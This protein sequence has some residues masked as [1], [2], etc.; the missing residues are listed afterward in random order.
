MIFRNKHNNTVGKGFQPFRLIRRHKKTVSL[1]LALLFLAGFM[2]PQKLFGLTGGPSSPEVSSPSKIT[3]SK[4]VDP[5][6][7]DL[8]YSISLL[9]VGDYPL[10]LSYNPDISMDQEASWVGLGWTLNPGSISRSVRGLPDDFKGKDKVEKDFN[11]KANVKAGLNAGVNLELFGIDAIGVTG[12]LGASVGLFY[13]N[14]QGAGLNYSLSPSITVGSASKGALTASMGINGGSH[15]NGISMQ[16]SLSFPQRMMGMESLTIS[17]KFNSLSGLKSVNLNVGTKNGI[18]DYSATFNSFTDRSYKPQIK[19]PMISTHGAFSFAGGGEVFGTF[20]SG[21]ITGYYSQQHLKKKHKEVPAFGYMYTEAAENRSDA[22]LD[23]KREKDGTFTSRK[24]NLPLPNYTYDVFNISGAGMSGSFRAHR[25]DVGVLY[26][27]YVKSLGGDKAVKAVGGF[28]LSGEVGGGNLVKVGIDLKTNNSVN[29]SGKWDNNN[30]IF[31]RIDPVNHKEASSKGYEPFYFK[32]SG[33]KQVRN[34]PSFYNRVLNRNPASV[35]LASQPKAKAYQTL[36]GNKDSRELKNSVYKDKRERRMS[37]VSYLTADI[38]DRMALNRQIKNYPLNKTPLNPGKASSID[39]LSGHR[40]KH[41]LSQIMLQNEGKRYVYGIPTYNNMKKEASFNVRDKKAN[42]QNGFVS[43]NAGKSNST[44]NKAGQNHYYSATTTPAYAYS[45]LLTSVVSEDY[46]DISG[47]GPTPDDMGTYTRFNYSRVHKNYKWRSPYRKNKANYQENKY[48]LDKENMA[49]YVYGKKEVWYINSIETRNYV[50]RF[51]IS[52]RK[53]G[54]GVKG[55]N[56]GKDK[57][58]KLKKLDKIQLFTRADL[59]KHGK[60]A[61]PLKTVHFEYDY[62]LCPGIPNQQNTNKGKLTLQ[63]IY[64]T[65]GNSSKGRFSPYDFT[66]HKGNKNPSYKLKSNDRFGFYKENNCQSGQMSNSEF[67]YVV[68]DTSKT[69]RFIKAW[70]LKKIQVPSGGTINIHYESD[71]YSYVQDKRAMQMFK[72][73]GFSDKRNPDRSKFTRKLYETQPSYSVNNYLF[74]DLKEPVTSREELKAYLPDEDHLY[75]KTKVDVIGSGGN[76]PSDHYEYISGFAKYQ[77]FGLHQKSKNGSSYSTAWI[78]L[79]KPRIGDYKLKRKY[80][81]KKAHPIAKRAWI[82]SKN[83]IPKH[84]FDRSD[85]TD[86]FGNQLK[87]AL[88]SLGEMMTML[89]SLN[90]KLIDRKFAKK[91]KLN[92]SIVRLNVP[93]GR[94][95]GGGHR[96]KKIVMSD[97]WSKMASKGNTSTYGNVYD[98]TTTRNGEKISS[99]VISY[100][101]RIGQEENPFYQPIFYKHN[102]DKL[103]MTKPFGSSFFPGPNVGYS[104]IEIHDLPRPGANPAPSGYKVREFYTAKDFP[105]ITERTNLQDEHKRRNPFAN[106]NPFKFKFNERRAVSQ[107]YKVVLNDMHGKPKAKYTYRHGAKMPLNGVEYKYKTGKHGRLKNNVK[108]V[109]KDKSIKEATLGVDIDF[110]VDARQQKSVTEMKGININTDGFLASIIPVVVPV[111]LPAYKKETVLFR[112]IVTTKVIRKKGIIDEVITY[113]NGSKLKTENL[114]FDAVTGKV[115]VSKNQNKYGNY[116]YKTNIPAHHKYDGMG[117]AYRN[118][119]ASFEKVQVKNGKITNRQVNNYLAKGDKLYWVYPDDKTTYNKAWVLKSNKNRSVLIDM[120]GDLLPNAKYNLTVV[121]SGYDDQSRQKVGKVSSMKNPISGNKLDLNRNIKVLKASA[122]RYK[123][124]WQTYAGFKVEHV[125][126]KCKCQL[127]NMGKGAML[128]ELLK[129]I[130]NEAEGA[131]INNPRLAKA[132]KQRVGDTASFLTL[133][134]DRKGNLLIGGFKLNGRGESHC[135]VE[136]EKP[137]GFTLPDGGTFKNYRYVKKNPYRCGDIYN[138]KVDF[139]YSYKDTVY[140]DYQTHKEQNIVRKTDTVTLKVHSECFP[141]AHCHE[142][143]LKSYFTCNLKPGDIVNPFVIGILGNW[144]SYKQ[145]TYHTS[146][147]SDRSQNSGYYKS[148]TP[149][150]W[151]GKPANDWVWKKETNLIDPFERSLEEEDPLGNH[152]ANIYGYSYSHVKASIQNGKHNRSGYDGFE[153]YEYYGLVNTFGNCT[154]QKHMHFYL[155]QGTNVSGVPIP[156]S[157]QLKYISD[158]D[159]HTGEYSARI[160]SAAP[161]VMKRKV[162]PYKGGGNQGSSPEYKLHPDDYVGI[163][164]PKPGKYYISA[165]VKDKL[166][167]VNYNTLTYQ[168]PKVVVTADG[169][170]VTTINPSGPVVDG[171]QQMNGSFVIPKNTNVVKVKL[172]T[173]FGVAFFD[174]FRIHP[175]NAQMKSYVYN[176]YNLRHTATLDNNNYAIFFQ[177]NEEGEFVGTKKETSN[178]IITVKNTRHGSH[179]ADK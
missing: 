157:K 169:S 101:P 143:P 167:Y 148:F 62:S 34:N 163:F 179:K 173:D 92:K 165:W 28:N 99:G 176:P 87:Q 110:V 118:M 123:D 172:A 112:S 19:Y 132:I 74:V 53:D 70:K 82:Y 100:E 76:N 108:V 33:E 114:A 139:V 95:L 85:A 37:P 71:D 98:Y 46:V 146:R 133:D 56:G 55:E 115:L 21:S 127:V 131:R 152:K 67:P 42:C 36:H 150:T 174:D 168:A 68:Q 129:T 16:P 31:K 64:Y 9:E 63:K 126:T 17:S 116:T 135:K 177:Y 41:H 160:T 32:M 140:S 48:S 166:A 66:Y 86:K 72:I 27:S 30:E 104:H 73:Q 170:K 47:D 178:G 103:F 134:R 128:P 77:D 54:L 29:T 25:G 125:P 94:K 39:R 58:Q 6:T 144:R 171:W 113:K 90:S 158:K 88:G 40:K 49:S 117:P 106:L 15:K 75:F 130:N 60:N 26:D 11:T 111:P 79:K 69:N 122:S 57:S 109:Q 137:I 44:D 23:Y 13:D 145:Y 43:Y 5:F 155:P 45:Y 59:K 38:A 84:A 164:T 1:T 81:Q 107:G 93:D 151:S 12:K 154:P 35:K 4:M 159:S 91:V 14:Y 141:I 153:D 138:F 24:P 162:N 52:D 156:S 50:A 65:Y 175:Y 142:E 105:V 22:L 80:K 161:V 102:G 83:N 18:R 8:D 20:A 120:K 2:R 61:T 124:E 136:I 97:K 78:K 119:L 89:K 7:G 147:V 10:S 121:R 149:F 96:V 51:I 3:S